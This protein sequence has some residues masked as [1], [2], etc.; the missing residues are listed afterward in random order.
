MKNEGYAHCKV[1][2]I[3]D[4]TNEKSTEESLDKSDVIGTIGLFSFGIGTYLISPAL[5]FISCGVL[6]MGLAIVSARKG[7]N[8]K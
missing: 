2:E 3:L 1:G 6:C 7:V 8:D 5:M 4:E